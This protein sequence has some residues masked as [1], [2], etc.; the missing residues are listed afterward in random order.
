MRQ[1][2][3]WM[4]KWTSQAVASGDSN[5]QIICMRKC[6]TAH[7][8]LC[9]AVKCMILLGHLTFYFAEKAR[10]TYF[11]W[12]QLRY[13]CLSFLKLMATNNNNNK[14]K[15]TKE[16]KKKKKATFSSKIVLLRLIS[17]TRYEINWRCSVDWKRRTNVVSPKS[18]PRTTGSFRCKFSKISLT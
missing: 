7:K 1:T 3:K 8:L 18:W 15:K 10:R 4:V 14:K 16:K 6:K 17:V 13:S 9:V 12:I 5:R 2:S 11:T